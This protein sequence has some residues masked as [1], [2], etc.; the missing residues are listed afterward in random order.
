[1]ERDG[2][3]T[4]ALTLAERIS[5]KTLIVTMTTDLFAVISNEITIS[6]VLYVR[7]TQSMPGSFQPTALAQCQQQLPEH[8][9]L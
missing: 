1:M 7:Y 4:S 9:L 5:R 3:T 2:G 8:A 6:P